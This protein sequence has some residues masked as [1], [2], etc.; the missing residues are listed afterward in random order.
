MIFCLA[1]MLA[2]ASEVQ[3]HGLSFEHWVA[4]TFFGGFRPA[5]ATDKW[6]IP[7]AA[8]K[9]HG[10]IPVNP[11]A[12]QYEEPVLLGDAAATFLCCCESWAVGSMFSA[13]A[14]HASEVQRYA[15]HV[16]HRFSC[17]EKTL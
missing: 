16:L 1:T 14:A 9:D 15:L 6:D 5:G 10:R 12:T 2:R 7:A 13:S 17:A 4:D 11:K 3:R 8:N